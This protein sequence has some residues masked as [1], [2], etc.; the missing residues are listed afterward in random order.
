[1]ESGL[2]EPGRAIWGHKQSPGVKTTSK[3]RLPTTRHPASCA[4]RAAQLQDLYRQEAN[5]PLKHRKGCAEVSGE[6]G[7]LW[8]GLFPFPPLGLVGAWGDSPC[9]WSGA[10]N[11]QPARGICGS[12]P[13]R[14][15]D[16]KEQGVVVRRSECHQECQNDL[17]HF[18]AF[19]LFLVPRQSRLGGL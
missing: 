4:A 3:C 10:L 13:L 15:K 12:P 14:S 8:S 16:P 5:V 11:P 18:L 6:A 7:S 17:S 1:M 19:Y 9:R 2:K